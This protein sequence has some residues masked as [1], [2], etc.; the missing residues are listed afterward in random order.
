MSSFLPLFHLARSGLFRTVGS[1]DGTTDVDVVVIGSAGQV[2]EAAVGLG[3][4]LQVERETCGATEEDWRSGNPMGHIIQRPLDGST[5]S[6][7]NDSH[8][9]TL[10]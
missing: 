3:E 5:G 1:F 10:M 2:V 9:S 6:L 4:R 8:V 7:L